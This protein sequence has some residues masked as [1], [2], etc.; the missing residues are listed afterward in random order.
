[1]ELVVSSA[2]DGERI[3]R[4]V[5]LAGG[6]TRAEA[7]ALVDDGAVAC[8]GRVVTNRSQ[9]VRQGDRIDI[10][11]PA[12]VPPAALVPDPEVDV[13]VVYADEQVIVVDKAPGVVVHP[14][15]G[16][17]TGTLVQ[18]LVGR[19]P[20]MADHRWPD[21]QRPGIVHRLDKGTS[22]LLVVARTP[23]A[24]AAL[25]GQLRARAMERGYL[26]LVWGTIDGDA[27]V[28]DAPLGRSERDPLRMAVRVGGRRAVTR[29]V[30]RARFEHPGMATLVACQ[31]E[32]GRTHQ[33]RAHL[34]AIGHPVV[35]DGRYRGRD[36]QLGR[37]FLH[38]ERLAFDDPSTG[39]RR[40]FASP[41]PADL[42]SLL[43]GLG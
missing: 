32:T 4:L 29:Y 12:P 33:I 31:L 43:D 35:G 38:A 40:S 1:V 9:R 16:H 28:I 7:S 25:S 6:L 15:A 19:F 17:R 41:L 37:P 14:G 13:D 2:L 26:A 27:G 3:D 39:E 23:L 21:P 20:D 8:A 34:A 10:D 36:L 24:L 5:A 42:Q 22:G 18:G 11:L 30:V